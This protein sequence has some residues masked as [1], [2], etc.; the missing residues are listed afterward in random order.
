MISTTA[1]PATT[2]FA[3]D[4]SHCKFGDTALLNTSLSPIASTP[5]R[6]TRTDVNDSHATNANTRSTEKPVSETGNDGEIEDD[7]ALAESSLLTFDDPET[8]L[9][10]PVPASQQPD[11]V[12]S[13]VLDDEKIRSH[14]ALE[15]EQI[16]GYL[17]RTRATRLLT[18][19]EEVSLALRVARGDKQAKD[20]LTEA[21]LRLVISIARRYS[22]PGIPLADLIQEGN[23]GLIRAVEKFDPR[24]GFRFSTYAT[25]WIRRAIARAVINQGRT[26]R[27]PVYVAE[28]IH[29]VVKTAG[30]LRQDLGR[31][32]S[33][34]EIGEA[35]S[36]APDRVN[37]IMRVAM[38]PISL[39]TPVGDKDSAQL[40]DFVHARGATPSDV[41]N[42]LIRREQLDN[43]LAKLTDR[44]RDVVRMRYGLDDGSP[45]TLEEVGRH[46]QVTRERVRQ[47]ELRAIKK[48]RRL[49]P[50]DEESDIQESDEDLLADPLDETEE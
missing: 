48:L 18:A 29:K 30:T 10:A 5:R 27:I 6:R 2:N 42:N 28:M 15:T 34:D 31:E 47:I 36:V 22:V 9:L 8:L 50:F 25:W 20:T 43:V 7:I 35:L 16:Q 33:A 45:R 40:Q 4:V 24:R 38:E 39:E 1:P 3:A 11:E 23:I 41:A 44:E 37:E 46:F 21:N 19:D 26:I 14:R 13:P 12:L 49:G 32:P 17:H